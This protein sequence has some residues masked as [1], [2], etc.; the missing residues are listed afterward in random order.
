MKIAAIIA[1]LPISRD[2]LKGNVNGVS[3]I[4]L[5]FAKVA[6]YYVNRLKLLRRN[7]TDRFYLRC[8]RRC[9]CREDSRKRQTSAGQLA[10]LKF[11]KTRRTMLLFTSDI[12]SSLQYAHR[13]SAVRLPV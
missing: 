6:A 13:L 5:T 1:G 4:E 9:G 10:A 12:T 7:G 11:L 8:L 2:V 3:V